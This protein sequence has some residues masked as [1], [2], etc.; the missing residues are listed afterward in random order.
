SLQRNA[1]LSMLVAANAMAPQEMQR[2]YQELEGIVDQLMARGGA[3]QMSDYTQL[4]MVH[5]YR[6]IPD[7]ALDAYLAH[8][9]TAAGQAFAKA[10]FDGMEQGIFNASARYGRSLIGVLAELAAETSS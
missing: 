10:V 6:D 4:A 3:E 5:T 2:S 8:L 1:A 9:D 7:S